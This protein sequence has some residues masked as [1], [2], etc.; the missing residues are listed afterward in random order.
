MFYYLAD[1]IYPEWS[2][3]VKMIRNGGRRLKRGDCFAKGQEGVPEGTERVF[4][5]F[6]SRCKILKKP[7]RFLKRKNMCRIMK[8]CII[9]HKMVVKNTPRQLQQWSFTVSSPCRCCG[10]FQRRP[11]VRVEIIVCYS[12][13]NRKGVLGIYLGHYGASEVCFHIKRNRALDCKA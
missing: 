11:T 13:P 4:G 6:R 12:K 7:C 5:V 9:L 1:E 3:F 10:Y 8:Y 2:L